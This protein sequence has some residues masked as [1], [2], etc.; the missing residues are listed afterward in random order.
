MIHQHC[1]DFLTTDQQLTN[2]VCYD[3]NYATT[4]TPF[5]QWAKQ[6]QAQAAVDGLGMLVEQAALTF[7]R[8][9]DVTVDTQPVLRQL[10]DQIN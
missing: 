10:R 7:N 2:M 9:H 5:I 4:P 6:Q 8:W 3:L 1:L